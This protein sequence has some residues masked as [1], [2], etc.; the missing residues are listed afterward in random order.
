MR[1]PGNIMKTVIT[2]RCGAELCANESQILR[3]TFLRT[4]TET[5]TS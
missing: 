1:K 5:I 3:V 4:H 2:W